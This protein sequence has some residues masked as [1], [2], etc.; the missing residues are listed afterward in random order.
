[1]NSSEEDLAYNLHGQSM[2]R[3][4]KRQA[5]V[6]LTNDYLSFPIHSPSQLVQLK[7]NGVQTGDFPSEELR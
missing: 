1:M 4:R 6:P 3:S 7:A 2:D 5:G